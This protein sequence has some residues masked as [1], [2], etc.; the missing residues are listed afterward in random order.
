[1]GGVAVVSHALPSSHNFL[2]INEASVMSRG[3]LSQKSNNGLTALTE[4]GHEWRKQLTQKQLFLCVRM[5]LL[6]FMKQQTPHNAK[7]DP[8]LQSFFIIV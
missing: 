1:M 8:F 5:P 3:L 6:S 7:C 2:I 4:M